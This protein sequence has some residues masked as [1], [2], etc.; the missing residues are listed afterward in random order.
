MQANPAGHG[1]VQPF[2]IFIGAGKEYNLPDPQPFDRETFPAV[3]AF[4]SSR[5]FIHSDCMTGV[6]YEVSKPLGR[7]R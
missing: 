6:S 3:S 7:D 5:D 2:S 1:R 4:F